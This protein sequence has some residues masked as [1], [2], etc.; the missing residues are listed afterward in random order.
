M[1]TLKFFYLNNDALFY[2][3]SGNDKTPF[4]KKKKPT[5]TY[6]THFYKLPGAD[7]PILSSRYTIISAHI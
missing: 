6:L 1:L 4:K 7:L 2:D 3:F 5:L